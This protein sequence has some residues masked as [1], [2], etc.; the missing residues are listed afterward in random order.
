[1]DAVRREMA[2]NEN[3]NYD[4]GGLVDETLIGT[5]EVPISK[6]RFTTMGRQL[7]QAGIDKIF[8]SVVDDGWLK[9]S[10]PTVTLVIRRKGV[11]SPTRTSATSFSAL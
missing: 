9:F 3:E 1:M 11:P 4:T 8:Q 5:F 2:G 10:M 7:R 6:L